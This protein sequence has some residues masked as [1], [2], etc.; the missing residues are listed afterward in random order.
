MQGVNLRTEAGLSRGKTWA[1]DAAVHPQAGCWHRGADGHVRGSSTRP[2]RDAADLAVRAPPLVGRLALPT[3]DT[4]SKVI[5]PPARSASAPRLGMH[6][7]RGVYDRMLRSVTDE[8]LSVP[9]LGSE[10]TAEDVTGRSSSGQVP[11]ETFQRLP[12]T[13]VAAPL[14]R[15]DAFQCGTIL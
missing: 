15:Q 6:W 10:G 9:S 2:R 1:R 3:T 14:E 13:G 11:V 7:G 8:R 4:V 12:T 5:P